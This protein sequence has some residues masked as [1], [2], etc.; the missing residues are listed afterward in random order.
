M[1]L[2]AA[3]MTGLLWGLAVAACAAGTTDGGGGGA[4]GST[5]DALAGDARAENPATGDTGAGSEA[6]GD[7]AGHDAASGQE[8]GGGPCADGAGQCSGVQPQT[9]VNG[10]WQP[11]GGPCPYLCGNGV[12]TGTCTPGAVQCIG[13]QPQV[14][15]SA[16]A[17][18]NSGSPCA[19][20]CNSGVCAGACTPGT[21]QCSGTST[22]TCTS[23][24]TWQTGSACP[25]LCSA[26]NCTGTCS[27]NATQ[28]SGTTPQRCDSTGAWQNGGA[29]PYMCAAGQCTGTCSPNTTESCASCGTTGTAT[30]TAAYAWGACAPPAGV[31]AFVDQSCT[32]ACDTVPA[33]WVGVDRSYN[34][35]TGQH[36]YTTSDTEAACC[37][38]TVE[39]LDY[40][41]LYSASQSGLVPF[42]RCALP[43]GHFYTTDSGC[44]AAPGAINEGSLGWIGTSAVCGAVPLYRLVYGANDDHFYAVSAADESAAEAAGYTLESIAGYVWI[45][46]EI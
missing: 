8:G 41:Y 35:S 13:Q 25:Y 26:G 21:K 10:Q 37:G 11:A 42:Y 1:K 27:P 19:N 34:S 43:T 45:S 20:V 6:A 38:Y 7:S 4:D 23:G 18:Q 31:C 46:P 39:N 40:Y 5:D 33:C 17:W 2:V 30:C 28:C 29:C 22:Q 15:D 36:F 9:C 24:G 12:C 32:A 16:G 44:E 14:C 3:L